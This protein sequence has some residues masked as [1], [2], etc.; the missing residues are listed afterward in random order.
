[1]GKKYRVKYAFCTPVI[2]QNLKEQGLLDEYA[3]YF[4]ADE[5][6]ELGNIYRGNIIIGT[7]KASDLI[8]KKDCITTLAQVSDEGIENLTLTL[9]KGTSLVKAIS[10]LYI[11]E[12]NDATSLS[13]KIDILNGDGPGSVI[14]TA[15]IEILDKTQDRTLYSREEADDTFFRLDAVDSLE[16]IDEIMNNPE[17]MEKLINAAEQITNALKHI[18]ID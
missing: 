11:K 3:V 17:K 7:A 2:Y 8:F 4:I 12:Y 6:E 18:I 13:E 9:A 16:A 1:M 5:D 15:N 14:Q 10:D